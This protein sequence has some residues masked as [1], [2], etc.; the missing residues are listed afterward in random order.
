MA[1]IRP[2]DPL[3]DLDAVI[4]VYEDAVISQTRGLY[5]DEQVR[6]WASHA[7]GN[8]DLA[9]ALERG[10]GMASCGHPHDPTSLEAFALLDPA[11]RL[12]LLYCR[13]RSARQGRASAL[14]DRLEAHAAASGVRRLRT[15]AS[16]LS[17]PLLL[18]RGWEVEAPED[19][20]FAEAWFHRWRMVKALTPPSLPSDQ[21]EGIC[22]D[23]SSRTNPQ[24]QTHT[25]ESPPTDGT[26]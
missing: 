4:S 15:E 20:R 21:H 16:Q 2:L 8:L 7:S 5:S 24:E 19:V 25:N 3:Q 6:A 13:G 17:R 14:L 18:R 10:F 9:A 11:D 22:T 26:P 1:W 12:A 23:G